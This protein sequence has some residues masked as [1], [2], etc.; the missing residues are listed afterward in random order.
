MQVQRAKVSVHPSELAVVEEVDSVLKKVERKEQPEEE[1]LGDLLMRVAKKNSRESE[2]VKKT[3]KKTRN[4]HK[5]EQHE[6]H[7]REQ[8]DEEED[9]QSEGEISGSAPKWHATRKRC[10]G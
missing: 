7:G 10:Q 9:L 8:E 1:C 3:K 6:D 2:R 5:E 4:N